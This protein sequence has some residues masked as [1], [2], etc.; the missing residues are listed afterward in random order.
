ML[1]LA[2]L[3][4]T[5]TTAQASTSTPPVPHV[6]HFTASQFQDEAQ[7]LPGALV[8]AVE[9]DLEQSP[10]QYLADSAAAVDAVAVIKALKA[11]GVNVLG[12]RIDGTDLTVNVATSTDAAIVRATGATAK[13]GAPAKLSTAGRVFHTASS[14]YGGQ[15]YIFGSADGSEFRC[16]LGFAGHAIVGGTS[17]ITSA[18]HCLGNASTSLYYLPMT[19][20]GADG[21]PSGGPIG[22][23]L[24]AQFNGGFDWGLM[25]DTNA[26]LPQT[27]QLYLWGSGSPLN[28][29]GQTAAIVNS[30]ICKSGSTTG[31]TCGT[32]LAVDQPVQVDDDNGLAHDVNA[33]ITDACVQPG[34]SGGA[35]EVG[36]FAVGITSASSDGACSAD[37]YLSVFFPMIS[38]NGGPS[39]Q[40]AIGSSWELSVVPSVPVLSAPVA[41]GSIPQG[42]SITGTL[43]NVD[44]SKSSVLVYLDGSTT[45]LTATISA[46]GSTWSVD[47]GILPLGT[48]TVITRSDWG[49]WSTGAESSTVSFT[50]TAPI[51]VDRIAGT[52]RYDG[53]V[54][55]AKQAFPTTA[56]VV[57][58]ATGL[59]YP[60]ALSAAPVAAHNN[61]PLLLAPGT[62][63]PNEVE[64]EIQS[65]DP[66]SIV[67]VGGV[68]SVSPN[69]VS[70]L[71]TAVPTA[72]VT[73]A[74]GTDRYGSSQEV[75]AS[76]FPTGATTAFIAN[77]ANFPDALSATSAAASKSAP[78]ILVP[79]GSSSLDS[80]TVGLLQALGVTTLVI[81]GGTSSISTGIET[82]LDG[83]FGTQNVQR[84][85][86]ADRYA[87]ST[88]INQAYF[89][90]ADHLYMATGTNFP[91]ALAGGVLAAVKSSP[92]LV[93]QPTCI[94]SEELQALATWDTTKLTLLGGTSALAPQVTALQTCG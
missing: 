65:L 58:I 9:K 36:G 7:Q 52:D 75:T 72:T 70:Q 32:V 31:W 57:Y 50:V 66:M 43:A 61:G 22:S 23:V 2:G 79:G 78:V 74:S 85:G 71:Q 77:G 54:Q 83:L 15:G 91:D 46:T 76:G 13:L 82:Q 21:G 93:A 94:P 17:Q 37:D 45:P 48:H 24:S 88:L 64:T 89:P 62:S 49:S 80:N 40:S 41:N 28:I 69:V 20:P 12:S 3:V 47:P 86:G 60:D 59:N 90:A 92:L 39:V 81:T 63:L 26:S 11:R 16:S 19:Q 87:T 53:A 6:H 42:A 34:D 56:P 25:S 84:L 44:H 4:A 1:V 55:I 8:R 51:T 67:V 29:V 73:R 35:A 38:A 27:P 30:P 68:N 10:E 18:G 14:I 5:S 33:I